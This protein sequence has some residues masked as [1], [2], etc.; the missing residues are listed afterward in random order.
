M[1]RFT[2]KWSYLNMV[3]YRFAAGEIEVY[4]PME[5]HM[6]QYRQQIYNHNGDPFSFKRNVYDAIGGA[7]VRFD[8]YHGRETW[9]RW[10]PELWAEFAAHL[11]QKHNEEYAW[12][13]EF[14][15]KHDYYGF[16]LPVLSLPRP[17]YWDL[18]A[19]CWKTEPWHQTA[20]VADAA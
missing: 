12:C 16:P 14:Q 11:E 6:L 3:G 4:R 17:I 1:Q 5:D 8:N 15:R 18:D 9:N 13:V 20:E 7:H 19:N 2:W 10:T